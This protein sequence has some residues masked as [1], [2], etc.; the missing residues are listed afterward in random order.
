MPSKVVQ[1]M[2]SSTCLFTLPVLYL[3]VVWFFGIDSQ[4][5]FTARQHPVAVDAKA[6]QALP[7]LSLTPTTFLERPTCCPCQ[8]ASTTLV[9]A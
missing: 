1:G 6:R 8:S 5:L 2:I 4:D 9:I 7:Q 3:L